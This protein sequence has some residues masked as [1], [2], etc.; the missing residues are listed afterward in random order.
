[1]GAAYSLPMPLDAL[2]QLINQLEA[3]PQWRRQGQFRRVLS[4]WP[5]VVGAS[6]AAQTQPVRIEQGTLFVAV[7]NPTWGQTLTFERPRILDKLNQ[8]VKPPI[9]DIRFSTGDWFRRSRDQRERGTAGE[10]VLDLEGLRSHPSYLATAAR[11]ASPQQLPKT[12]LEAFQDWASRRQREA[13]HQ[14][15]CPDCHCPCPMGELKRWSR[16]SLCAAKAWQSQQ[17]A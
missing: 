7:A 9:Q 6:V 4:C 14:P 15:Q 17:H 5:G 13:Q 1:M 16:C 8:V 12:A 3:Q 2:G 10:S 11:Q